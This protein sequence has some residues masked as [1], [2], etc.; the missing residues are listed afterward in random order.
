MSIEIR[1]ASSLQMAKNR[2]VVGRMTGGV[3]FGGGI[4]KVN[5]KLVRLL[6][7]IGYSF[8]PKEKGIRI[9]KLNLNGSLKQGAGFLPVWCPTVPCATSRGVWTEAIMRL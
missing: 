3:M 2:Q 8:M 9:R 6:C 7:N 4:E 1:D 5:W